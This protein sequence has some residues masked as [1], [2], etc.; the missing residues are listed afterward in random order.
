MDCSAFIN[1]FEWQEFKHLAHVAKIN[2]LLN[3]FCRKFLWNIS[4]IA[5]KYTLSEKQNKIL[6]NCLN[7]LIKEL[8]K[9]YQ[10]SNKKCTIC[11]KL[12][13]LKKKLNESKT[14]DINKKLEY[15]QNEFFYDDNIIYNFQFAEIDSNSLFTYELAGSKVNIKINKLHPFASDL[16]QSLNTKNEDHKILRS[17][18]ISFVEME[19]NTISET[20]REK[21]KEIRYE[22]GKFLKKLK[23]NRY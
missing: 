19:L 2:S 9:D 21:I 20:E 18:F 17:L 15:H 1:I 8:P 13:E 23:K 4:Y 7:S 16:A 5:Q 14:E 12:I 11:A 6:S 10:C 22:W 3:P